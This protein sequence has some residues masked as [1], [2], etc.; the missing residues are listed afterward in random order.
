MSMEFVFVENISVQS[1]RKC[2]RSCKLVF[3]FFLSHKPTKPS[4]NIRCRCINPIIQIK[5]FTGSVIQDL[6]RAIIF[7]EFNCGICR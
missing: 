2:F 3:C 4:Q 5:K 7:P 1:S 6:C